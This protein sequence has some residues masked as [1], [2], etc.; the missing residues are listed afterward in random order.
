MTRRRPRI[1]LARPGGL[2]PELVPPPSDADL[3]GATYRQCLKWAADRD[4]ILLRERLQRVARARHYHER[5]VRHLTGKHVDRALTDA[6]QWR[7]RQ[8]T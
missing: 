2:F 4:G 3:R 1:E 8:L 6:Q 7:E 5:W